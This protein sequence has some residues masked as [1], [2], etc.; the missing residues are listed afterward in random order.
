MT[1][2]REAEATLTK[3]NEQIK[4]WSQRDGNFARQQVELW[5]E[6]R[7]ENLWCQPGRSCAGEKV[8]P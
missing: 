8:E 1:E 7:D 2:L 4:L 5:T 6:I 3:A